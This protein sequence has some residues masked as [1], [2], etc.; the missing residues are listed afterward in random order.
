MKSNAEIKQHKGLD[1]AR[2]SEIAGTKGLAGE[3][4][5]GHTRQIVKP[6]SQPAQRPS[7]NPPLMERVVRAVGRQERRG[8][9]RVSGGGH[10]W[11]CLCGFHGET[12]VCKN[13]SSV[14]FHTP[15]NGAF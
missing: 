4:D 14:C 5:V 3:R 13:Q 10:V 6:A 15:V 12:S 9:G 7:H 2:Y 8:E 1:V 11:G